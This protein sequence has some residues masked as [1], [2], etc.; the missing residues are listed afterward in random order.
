MT[1]KEKRF[2][3][4]EPNP[5]QVRV[6]LGG[7]I[8]AETRRALTLHE[9]AHPPVHYIPRAD[10]TLDLFEPS[11]FV[12]HCPHKGDASYYSATA[13]GI[14]AANA[15]WSYENP[16]DRVADLKGYLAFDPRKVDAIE[17][18]R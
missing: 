2:L 11:S 18:L 14:L 1:D 5:H 15:A 8:L 12:T 16:H 9:A 17:E 13:H 6:L 10:V 7:V 4:I 3:A